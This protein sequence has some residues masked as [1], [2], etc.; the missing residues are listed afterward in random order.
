MLSR[1]ELVYLDKGFDGEIPFPYTALELAAAL[2]QMINRDFDSRNLNENSEV[3]L[4]NEER[5]D[6]FEETREEV[7]QEQT[8]EEAQKAGHMQ[9]DF[10]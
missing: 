9:S 2:T 3:D 7:K 5:I 6:I 1:M 4:V 10:Q 8:I